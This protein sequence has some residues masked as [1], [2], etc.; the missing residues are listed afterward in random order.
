M[1]VLNLYGLVSCMSENDLEGLNFDAL[2]G[3]EEVRHYYKSVFGI[4]YL[5]FCITSLI[6]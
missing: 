2:E 3:P 5:I 4:M 6:E 1:A